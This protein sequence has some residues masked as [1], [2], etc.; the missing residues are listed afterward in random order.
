M[1]DTIEQPATTQSIFSIAVKHCPPSA[2]G[3]RAL[4]ELMDHFATDEPIDDRLQ[5]ADGSYIP[6][7]EAYSAV[8][9]V[10]RILG[11][12]HPAIRQLQ[13]DLR[14]ALV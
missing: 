11:P 13:H 6:N 7:A 4:L 9:A 12:L 10:K 8:F 1:E 3:S 14:A 2:I 5:Q